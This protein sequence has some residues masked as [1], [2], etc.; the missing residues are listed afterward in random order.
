MPCRRPGGRESSRRRLGLGIH[1]TAPTIH[2]GFGAGQKEDLG[3][4]IQLEIFNLGP[5][6][7]RLDEG[8]RICQVIFEEVRSADGW[9]RGS[10]RCAACVYSS[11]G[12]AIEGGLRQQ[13]RNVAVAVGVPCLDAHADRAFDPRRIVGIAHAF[14]QRGIVVDRLAAALIFSRVRSA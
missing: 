5:W 4:P 12:S 8:M 3:S 14:E 13:P 7:I 2:A 1:V 9:L 6:I 11:M 10:V